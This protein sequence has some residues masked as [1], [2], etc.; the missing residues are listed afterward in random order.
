MEQRDREKIKIAADIQE[1]LNNRKLST[2]TKIDLSE[3]VEKK[4]AK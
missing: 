4:V 1:Y 3:V 2:S